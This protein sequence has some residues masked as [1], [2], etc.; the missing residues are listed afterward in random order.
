PA[1][2]VPAIA[3]VT[4]TRAPLQPGIAVAITSGHATTVTHERPPAA[5]DTKPEA[6]QGDVP[7]SRTDTQN[8]FLCRGPGDVLYPE[9]VRWNKV[10][11]SSGCSLSQ[12]R[13]RRTGTHGRQRTAQHSGKATATVTESR[14]VAR[15][16]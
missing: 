16:W 5:W 15:F 6:H 11:D 10:M 7:T 14:Y 12:V 4:G 9:Q 1:R 8:V 2:P 3:F 13:H